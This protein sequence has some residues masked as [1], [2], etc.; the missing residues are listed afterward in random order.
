MCGAEADHLVR[1]GEGVVAEDGAEQRRARCHEERRRTEPVRDALLESRRG[2]SATER[3]RV[4]CFFFQERG[5][6][7]ERTE[8]FRDVRVEL[9]KTPRNSALVF[10]GFGGAPGVLPALAL[11]PGPQLAEV[12]LRGVGRRLRRS[13]R[14]R[15]GRR[16]L[17]TRRALLRGEALL[18]RVAP[19]LGAALDLVLVLVLAAT[20]R[21]A[22][23]RGASR[24]RLQVRKSRLLRTNERTARGRDAAQRE[25]EP[26]RDASVE[27]ERERERAR[28]SERQGEKGRPRESASKAR[29]SSAGRGER[30]GDLADA[31]DLGARRA[32]STRCFLAVRGAGAK[33]GGTSAAA[34]VAV[35]ACADCADC[36][37]CAGEGFWRLLR[38][39]RSGVGGGSSESGC[40]SSSHG[41]R[42]SRSAQAQS[43][44]SAASSIFVFR[45]E[46]ARRSTSARGKFEKKKTDTD[47]GETYFLSPTYV[48]R[49][50]NNN[51]NN[52]KAAP[53][54]LAG[55][56]VDALFA[57]GAAARSDV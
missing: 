22:N 42:F 17:C 47:C 30:A 3:A 45:E 6:I 25:R 27:R 40:V 1:V 36:A 20:L 54:L 26:R 12:E 44:S 28:R 35:A 23:A 11:Q 43:A 14:A 7:R 8:R 21:G 33:G 24:G 34:A 31:A 56:V 2:F 46:D 15:S 38:S 39:P 18:A 29:G 53:A 55:E 51:N 5:L 57:R 13:R 49:D 19:P 48:S 32:L 16:G 9:I 37:D 50:V 41:H 10:L 52:K 4:G